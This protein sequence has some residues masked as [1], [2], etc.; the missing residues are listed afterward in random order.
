M[1]G[2]ERNVVILAIVYVYCLD[3]CDKDELYTRI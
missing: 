1:D 3:N 2:D